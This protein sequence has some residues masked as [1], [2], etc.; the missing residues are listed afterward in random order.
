MLSHEITSIQ[1]SNLVYHPGTR[2]V[3]SIAWIK[4]ELLKLRAVALEHALMRARP[5][6]IAVR[7]IMATRPMGINPRWCDALAVFGD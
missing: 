3:D 2:R 1:S 4:L 7:P 6:G 5:C